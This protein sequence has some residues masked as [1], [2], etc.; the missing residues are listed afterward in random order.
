MTKFQTFRRL[1]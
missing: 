1:G